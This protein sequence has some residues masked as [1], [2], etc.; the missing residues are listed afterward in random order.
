MQQQQQISGMDH[1]GIIPKP[2]GLWCYRCTTYRDVFTSNQ[3]LAGHKHQHKSQGTWIRRT[4]MVLQV[5]CVVARAPIAPML[6]Q[7]QNLFSNL[8]NQLIENTNIDD[9]EELD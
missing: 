5:P 9:Q 2:E 1:Q 6:I 8:P 4:A 3:G 7:D